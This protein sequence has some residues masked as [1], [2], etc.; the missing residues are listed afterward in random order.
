MTMLHEF[1]DSKPWF[2][3][4]RF[5]YGTGLPIAWQ[6]WVLLLAYTATVI[7]LAL[8]ATRSGPVASAGLAAVVAILT[9]GL[10][11]IAKARTRG[12]WR[13]RWRWGEDD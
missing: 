12:E 10:V 1:V 6:G 2:L 3:P 9:V 8:L 11:V 7:G 4:K 5:G 13:W